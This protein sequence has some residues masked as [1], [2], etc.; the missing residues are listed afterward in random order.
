MILEGR[1]SLNNKQVKDLA[2]VVTDDDV[3]SVDGNKVH[4]KR[5]VVIALNKPKGFLCTRSDPEGRPTIYDLLPQKF[6]M[7]HHIGRLDQDSEGLILLTNDGELSQRLAHPSEGVE[8]EYEVR[9]E[10]KF[11]PD[12]LPRLIKGLNTKEGF[13]RAERAW[14]DNP[15]TLH[16]ILK[17]GLKR[18]IREMLFMLGHEVERLIRV[19]IGGLWNK[20]IAKG[21][22]RELTREEVETHFEKRVAK[23]RSVGKPGVM[24]PKKADDDDH[25]APKSAKVAKPRSDRPKAAKPWSDKPKF[26]KPGFDKPKFD[27]SVVGKPLKKRGF[28][29]E[30]ASPKA[31]SK[32]KPKTFRGKPPTGKTLPPKG[33]GQRSRFTKKRFGDS[34]ERGSRGGR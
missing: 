23:K 1:V 28:E 29:H 12:Q 25:F 8:K 9:L 30:D 7:L 10:D 3:V 19:R 6:Q 2:T 13:A 33:S 32:P 31:E 17:Q 18:Q 4:A 22:F 20:G 34:G 5:T 26:D 11:D 16:M 21:A 15:W 24:R 14:L 27:K